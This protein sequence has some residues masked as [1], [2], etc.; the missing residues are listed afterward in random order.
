[1]ANRPISVT[2]STWDQRVDDQALKKRKDKEGNWNLARM[3][4]KQKS[5]HITSLLSVQKDFDDL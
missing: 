1:V 5:R 3:G 2:K 4:K